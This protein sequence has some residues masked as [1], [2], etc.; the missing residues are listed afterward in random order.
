MR[1]RRPEQRHDPVTHDLIHRALVVVDGLHHVLEH[2]VEDSTRLLWV[3]VSEQLHRAFE[4]GE[5]HRDLLAFAFECSLRVDDP[6]GEVL[7]RVGLRGLEA[8]RWLT[9]AGIGSEPLAAL[10]A[11]LVGRSV[12]RATGSADQGELCPA[13]GAKVSVCRSLLLAPGT[14]HPP[15]PRAWRGQVRRQ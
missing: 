11:E 3:A 7:R 12:C 10:L 8:L 6:F 1:D 15:L 9:T 14:L 13:L 4:I 5:E 2:G